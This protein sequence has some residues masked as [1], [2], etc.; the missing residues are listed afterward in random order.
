MALVV[1][2]KNE[3]TVRVNIDE[4][5]DFDKYT[6]HTVD[7][8]FKILPLDEVKEIEAI[9][10]KESEIYDS[11]LQVSRIFDSIVS[12]EGLKDEDGNSL[13]YNDDVR[14]LLTSTLWI[15]HPIMSEFWKVQAGV[16]SPKAYKQAKLKN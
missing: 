13:S 9:G 10:D 4:A 12:V 2:K 8:K 14:E 7:I 5:H 16:L 15:R 6:R 3:R 11:D 1:G